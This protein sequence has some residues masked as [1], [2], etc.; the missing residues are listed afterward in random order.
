VRREG[1]WGTGRSLLHRRPADPEFFFLQIKAVLS[2][3]VS[4]DK[5]GSVRTYTTFLYRFSSGDHN[6]V[7]EEEKSA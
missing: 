3:P 1:R 5:Y 7:V 2:R 4:E 6:R